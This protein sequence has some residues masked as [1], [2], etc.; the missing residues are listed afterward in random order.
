MS[1]TSHAAA[2]F[3]RGVLGIPILIGTFLIVAHGHVMAAL[4]G[5]LLF[6][7]LYWLCNAVAPWRPP[8][9]PSRATARWKLGLLL[10]ATS[11][12]VP[13]HTLL[14]ACLSPLWWV[15]TDVV[16]RIGVLLALGAFGLLRRL[17]RRV[18]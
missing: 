6:I 4:G 5:V 12:F 15:V 3:R 2:S 9:A 17:S 10:M 18:R 16:V 1:A 13:H 11:F 14:L 7:G 8:E